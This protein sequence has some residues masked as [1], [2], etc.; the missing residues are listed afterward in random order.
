MVL[1]DA[2]RRHRA[3]PACEAMIVL[4]SSYSQRAGGYSANP[5][6]RN[7]EFWPSMHRARRCMSLA[8]SPEKEVSEFSVFNL[9]E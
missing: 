4:S 1:A 5:V 9:P 8:R 6:E 2:Q 7:P 3:F